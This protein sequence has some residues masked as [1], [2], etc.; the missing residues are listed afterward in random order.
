M[1]TNPVSLVE[2]DGSRL[3]FNGA[4][5]HLQAANGNTIFRYGVDNTIESTL[6]YQEFKRLP[7]RSFLLAPTSGA[8]CYYHWMLDILP[9]LGLLERHG[10]SLESIDHFLVRF[11][12]QESGRWTRVRF[13]AVRA[14]LI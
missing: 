9:K 4:A 8:H 7:G 14:N 5:C 12:S 10:I 2:L 13:H 6:Q 1:Q 11:F 3:F